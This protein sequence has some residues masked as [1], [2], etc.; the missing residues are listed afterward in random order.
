MQIFFGKTNQTWNI[1]G[2]VMRHRNVF[3]CPMGALGMYLLARFDYTKEADNFDFSE[4][5]K[6]FD[7]KLLVDVRN[8]CNTVGI[9][10]IAYARFIKNVCSKLNIFT[11]KYAHFGRGVGAAI[12][13]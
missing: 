5:A 8:S 11:K 3:I 13:M 1:Y 2:R 7:I 6:W 9:T 4:N 12:G 10:D